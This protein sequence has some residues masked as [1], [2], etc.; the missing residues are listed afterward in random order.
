MATKKTATFTERLLAAQAAIGAV[1]A[2][3]R[4]HGSKGGGSYIKLPDLLAKARP[5]LREQGLLITHSVRFD[6]GMLWVATSIGD[7]TDSVSVELPTLPESPGGRGNALTCHALGSSLTY[8]R[9]YGLACLLG[10]SDVPD[11]D[12][13]AAEEVHAPQRQAR[14]SGQA[15]KATINGLWKHVSN[16]AKADGYSYT[17]KGSERGDWKRMADMLGVTVPDEWELLTVTD[18]ENIL[19]A[20]EAAKGA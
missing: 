19:A 8:L 12:G 11:D 17:Y 7:G 1:E 3:G 15:N 16:A 13:N 2:K 18:L 5:A 6:E 20:R 14:N 10:C 4:R 9:R